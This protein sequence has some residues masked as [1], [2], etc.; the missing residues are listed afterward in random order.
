MWF[1]LDRRRSWC[2][3]ADHRFEMGGRKPSNPIRADVNCFRLRSAPLIVAREAN[4]GESLSCFGLIS[5]DHMQR[6]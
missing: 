6:P 4:G 2:C 5:A 3:G 1:C